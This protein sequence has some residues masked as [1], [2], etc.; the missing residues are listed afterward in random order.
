MPNHYSIPIGQY[1]TR[2]L[3]LPIA[4]QRRHRCPA[5]ARG[6]ASSYFSNVRI[7]E[8]ASNPQ[9][10]QFPL[11][12]STLVKS[13]HG[14]GPDP[15]FDVQADQW[16]VRKTSDT[17]HLK[18]NTRKAVALSHPISANTVLEFDFESTDNGEYFGISFS[19]SLTASGPIELSFRL[20]GADPLNYGWNTEFKNYLPGTGQ[21]HYRIP[22]GEY[23]TGSF[24]YLLLV[25]A[26]TTPGAGPGSGR[27]SFSN[28]RFY[29]TTGIGKSRFS[30]D[31]S[32]RMKTTTDALGRTTVY[33]YDEAGR[34]VRTTFPDRT[35]T[36]HEYDEF[37]NCIATT[38]ELGRATRY[39]YDDRNRLIQT[40]YADGTSTCTQYDGTG[41]VV[42][43][44][45]ERDTETRFAYDKAGRLLRAVT[46]PGLTEVKTVNKYDDRGRRIE[47][48]DA[49]GI[50]TKYRY[51]KL[52]RLVQTTVLDKSHLSTSET[53]PTALQ[54]A[55]LPVHVSTIEY[56]SNGNVART[57][58]FDPRTYASDPRM[59]LTP[60]TS[61]YSPLL[62]NAASLIAAADETANKDAGCCGL[63]T[64]LSAAPSRSPMRMAHRLRRSTMPRAVCGSRS[65]NSAARRKAN[66]TSLA[67]SK[68]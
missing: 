32:G 7:Y 29:E 4:R 49:N 19:N 31:A 25:N 17:L 47:S 41:Q 65:T 5:T 35:F 51:D 52:D 11:D 18:G 13:W 59:N 16:E 67:G 23:A 12:L 62:T 66:T 1:A 40:I 43:T 30:Y 6:P 54:T 48:V 45:D 61:D 37:G 64:M 27:S 3:R 63:R 33:A 15:G 53:S 20:G 44:F 55:K 46:T 36:T 38:D 42:S 22:I 26:D 9:L 8:S 57:A 28:L 39:V 68:R 2:I 21:T 24:T 14:P 34:L 50:V 10:I 60:P 58:T 56:D